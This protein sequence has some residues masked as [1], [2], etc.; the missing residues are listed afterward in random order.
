MSIIFLLSCLLINVLFIHASDARF[1]MPSFYLTINVIVN[2]EVG[3]KLK[4]IP[5]DIT[6]SQLQKII[7][8]STEMEHYKLSSFTQIELKIQKGNR[9][10]TP[11]S[12]HEKLFF[13][14]FFNRNNDVVIVQTIENEEDLYRI[15]IECEMYGIRNHKSIQKTYDLSLPKERNTSMKELKYLIFVSEFPTKWSWIIGDMILKF[16][17]NEVDDKLTTHIIGADADFMKFTVSFA[18]PMILVILKFPDGKEDKY[19]LLE[20]TILDELKESIKKRHPEDN[21]IYRFIYRGIEETDRLTKL[22]DLIKFESEYH[23]VII[24]DIVFDEYI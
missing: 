2:H 9:I 3:F 15:L 4:M 23:N 17:G 13:T 8:E 18:K 24:F 20:D 6:V 11:A 5:F 7:A 1:E 10:I 19:I 16:M 21:R 14:H 12:Y 22:T